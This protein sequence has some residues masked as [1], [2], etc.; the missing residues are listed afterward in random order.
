MSVF[1]SQRERIECAA[2]TDRWFKHWWPKV[3]A[4]L[5][6]EVYEELH[7]HPPPDLRMIA[8]KAV[9]VRAF[10]RRVIAVIDD[11][12]MEVMKIAAAEAKRQ[13]KP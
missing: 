11:G 7:V 13:K 6:R 2:E 8:A 4:L 5:E 1:T 3:E 12:E 10:K 9:A